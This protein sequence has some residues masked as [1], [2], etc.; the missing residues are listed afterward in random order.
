MSKDPLLAKILKLGLEEHPE[1]ASLYSSLGEVYEMAD[2]LEL[3]VRSFRSAVEIASITHDPS[4]PTH[5]SSLQRAQNKLDQ[6]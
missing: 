3:A 1:S 4:L 2:M 5:E 6:R